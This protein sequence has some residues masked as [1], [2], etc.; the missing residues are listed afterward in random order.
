MCYHPPKLAINEFNDSLDRPTKNAKQHCPV[1][2]PRDFNSLAVGCG[3]KE[4]N[5]PGKP[6][7]ESMTTIALI[8][9]N[10]GDNVMIITD[11]SSS[12]ID[13]TFISN[14]LVVGDCSCEVMRYLH[15]QGP[16]WH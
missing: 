5:A 9:C 15:S 13:F 4:I 7:L 2:I 8:L 1:V 11:E 3:S 10:S 16:L 6:L 14:Y 12:L